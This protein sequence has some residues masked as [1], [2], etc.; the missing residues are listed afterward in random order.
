MTIRAETSAD[1]TAIRRVNIAAFGRE[2]EANLV[3]RLRGQAHTFSFVAVEAEAIVG[4]S[5]FS[6]V[7][8]AGNCADELLILGLAPMA[9]LPNYQRQGIGTLLIQHGLMTCAQAGCHAIVV[10]GHPTYYPRFGFVPAKQKGLQ[11]EY[12]VPEEAF[13]VLELQV[14]ALATCAGTVIYSPEFKQLE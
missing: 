1:I 5:F 13:M 7:T 10:L 6:P 11:C 3:D 2:D 12:T 9:V 8:I 4:H 14:G